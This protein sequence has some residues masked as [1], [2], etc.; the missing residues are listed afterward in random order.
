[1][2]AKAQTS[3]EYLLL[4]SSVILFVAIIALAVR[5]TITPA[6][7][8]AGERAAEIETKKGDYGV[9]P[10]AITETCTAGAVCGIYHYPEN[11][12]CPPGQMLVSA[13]TPTCARICNAE[14]ICGGCNSVPT[15]TPVCEAPGELCTSINVNPVTVNSGGTVD[16][17]VVFQNT[18][19][20]VVRCG[21]SPSQNIPVQRNIS[22]G[23]WETAHCVYT[24]TG[25]TPIAY[26]ITADHG[27]TQCPIRTVTV[28]PVPA[29]TCSITANPATQQSP[30]TSTISASFTNVPANAPIT[31]KCNATDP[32]VV[33]TGTGANP[34]ATRQCYYGWVPVDTAN[35]ANVSVAQASCTTT[36]TSRQ[37]VMPTCS[38]W[39]NPG[40]GTGPFNP[41]I[42][43]AFTNLPPSVNSADIRCDFNSWLNVPV[44]SGVA[45]GSCLLPQLAFDTN[46]SIEANAWHGSTLI[47]TCSNLTGIIGNPNAPCNNN[48][49]DLNPLNASF[50][51]LIVKPQYPTT[52]STEISVYSPTFSCNT[53]TPGVCTGTPCR[54][55]GS[56]V[57]RNICALIEDESDFDWNDFVFS[58]QVTD[59]ADGSM[60]LRVRNEACST[61]ANDKLLISFTFPTQKSV[62]SVEDGIR[63]NATRMKFEVWP[64]CQPYVGQTRSFVISNDT[65]G[66][67]PQNFPPTWDVPQNPESRPIGQPTS[68]RLE[69]WV[70]DEDAAFS[71]NYQLL[72]VSNPAAVTCSVFT[73]PSYHIIGCND[74]ANGTAAIRVR[75]TDSQGQSSEM[76]YNVTV[77]MYFNS[78]GN[79]N[80]PLGGSVAVNLSAYSYDPT[81][82][83]NELGYDFVSVQNPSRASCNF[84]NVG[85]ST[86]LNCTG[87]GLGPIWTVLRVI[88]PS[89]V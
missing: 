86:L 20:A 12:D 81:Y 24:N 70:W 69:D 50:Y 82:P 65:T 14:G 13:C 61:A 26:G 78:F 74:L 68:L 80:I 73:A 17:D 15:C 7:E 38:I 52:F 72:S 32:G 43:A 54:V 88:N 71:L 30:F 46:A 16:V 87:N 19:N 2:V 66:N 37:G 23:V 84:V 60:L 40:S 55:R 47:A 79:M 36:V 48:L 44:I 83:L 57:S 31:I 35:I 34:A 51:D 53:G 22:T 3:I 45:T 58:T 49:C 5:D 28:N 6:G 8:I 75:A 1:M 33:F 4:I 11:R 77:G 10:T 18:N 27:Y 67:P 63:K 76:T 64:R 9:T 21:T 62:R 29:A 85:G 56:Q 25:A 59:N 39:S 41:S 42:I 89:N